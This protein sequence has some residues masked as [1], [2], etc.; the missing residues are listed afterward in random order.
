MARR[1]S[2]APSAAAGGNEGFRPVEDWIPEIQKM[3]AGEMSGPIPG[4][5]GVTLYRVLDRRGGM[6]A[7]P[8]IQDEVVRSLRRRL[9]REQEDEAVA[10][11]RKDAFLKIVP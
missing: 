4:E 7:L 3:A 2:V 10:K 11:L 5:T 9:A 6:P 8:E 1:H